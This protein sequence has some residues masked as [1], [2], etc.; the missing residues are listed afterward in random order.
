M[1][2]VQLRPRRHCL[3]PTRSRAPRASGIEPLEGRVL[4]SAG[5]AAAAASGHG[6]APEYAAHSTVR[7]QTMEEWSA[8][9]WTWAFETKASQ[10][11]LLDPTGANA[12]VGDVGN[13]FFLAGVINESGAA[14]RTVTIPTGTPIFFPVIN[15]AADNSGDP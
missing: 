4:M 15:S 3:Q 11:P 9:W 10:S 6:P 12:R 2:H 8:Q 1:S 13:A 7:G 14:D 5:G